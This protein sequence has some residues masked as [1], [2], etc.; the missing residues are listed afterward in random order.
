M[1]IYN[2]TA[3]NIKGEKKEG[4]LEAKDEHNLAQNLHREGYILTSIQQERQ[5][6]A[7]KFSFKKINPL[8]R[9]SLIEKVIFIRHLGIMV[10]AG[11]SLPKALE[12]LV[13]QTKNAKFSRVI[14]EIEKNV[15]RGSS[16]ADSLSAHPKI[17]NQLFINM[18]KVGEVSG[19]LEK[20]L[21]LLADQLKKDHE[22]ISKVK[23]AMIYPAVI[24]AAMLAIGGIMMVFVVPK[25]VS[26]FEAFGSELPFATKLLIKTS[27][28]L[29]ENIFLFIGLFLVLGLI[30]KIISKK[31]SGGN[32]FFHSLILHLPIV[33][34]LVKK[35]NIARFARTLSSLTAGGVT[36]VESLD[37]ISNTLTNINYSQSLKKASQQISKGME[38]NK[39]LSEYKQLYPVIVSQMIA[40]GEE[41]GSLNDILIQLAEFYESEIQTTL[42]NLSA[43]I[44]PVLMLIIGGAVGFFAIS[45]IQPMYSIMGGMG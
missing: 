19:N 2:Y 29:S 14:S 11:V 35:I 9:I 38:L 1:P 37:I 31:S 25:L 24:L 42:N 22:L 43:I 40:V 30:F 44:E 26:V 3:K 32:K 4:I 18:I 28:L 39:T 27:T 8:A 36:I 12:I 13:H 5:K 45:I 17:F 34:S 33:G 6:G 7:E 21:F 23:G 41:T 15:K 16:L 10:K 20:I